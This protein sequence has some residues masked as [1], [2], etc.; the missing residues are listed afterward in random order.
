MKTEAVRENGS[1]VRHDKRRQN[2]RR[3]SAL[4]GLIALVIAVA[5]S[6]SVS[7]GFGQNRTNQVRRSNN[8][9]RTDGEREVMRARAD[10]KGEGVSGSA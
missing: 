2:G 9:A 6:A 10:I 5:M 1:T 7:D 8:Q 3:Q 4:I